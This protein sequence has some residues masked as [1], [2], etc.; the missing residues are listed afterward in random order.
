[1]PADRNTVLDAIALAFGHS[2]LADVVGTTALRTALSARYVEIA[3]GGNIDL[4]IVWDTI[5]DEAQ[6]DWDAGVPPVCAIKTWEDRLGATVLLPPHLDVLTPQDVARR[7]AECDVPRAEVQ[8]LFDTPEQRAERAAAAQQAAA[9]REAAA[10]PAAVAGAGGWRRRREVGIAAAIVSVLAVAFGAYRL[11]GLVGG[12]EW[13][14][15]GA[16]ELAGGIPAA[17][18]EKL[19]DQV[20]LRLSDDAWLAKPRAEIEAAMAAALRGLQDRGVA[21]VFVRDSAGTP[22]VSAQWSGFDVQTRFMP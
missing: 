11:V 7:A 16:M 2:K 21:V 17:S 22:R 14:S 8:A 13:D 19:G 4:Q 1:M 9:A 6:F 3:H 20:G 18:A 5:Q 12:G 15:L 10:A